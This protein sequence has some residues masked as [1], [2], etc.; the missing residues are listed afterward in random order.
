MLPDRPASPAETVSYDF[1]GPLVAALAQR[2]LDYEPVS[3]FTGTDAKLPAGLPPALDGRRRQVLAHRPDEHDRGAGLGPAASGGGRAGEALRGHRLGLFAAAGAAQGRGR[4]R[5][6]LPPRSWWRTA[7]ASTP[8]ATQASLDRCCLEV[9]DLRRR[10]GLTVAQRA[11]GEPLLPLPPVAYPAELRVER[12]VSSSALVAFEGNRYSVP[13][14]LAGQTA[15]VLA[16]LGEPTLRV[17]SA[18]GVLVATHRRLPAGAGQIVRSGADQAA[19]EQ[20]VLAAFTTRPPCARK[21]NR[22]PSIEALSLAAALTPEA[23]VEP[24]LPSLEIYASL[25]GAR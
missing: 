7:D 14:S 17:V 22:P 21:P 19:L 23:L 9:A 4:S 5:D 1:V 24:K 2:G 8:A 16:R 13:P 15:A 25:A 11:A 6:P 3:T 12:V 20:A 10:G 18:A